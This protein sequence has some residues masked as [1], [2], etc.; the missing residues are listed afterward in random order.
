M[1]PFGGQV[2]KYGEGLYAIWQTLGAVL[3]RS[4]D[5]WWSVRTNCSVAAPD[6]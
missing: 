3:R 6:Q 1:P 5:A 2:G 4:A